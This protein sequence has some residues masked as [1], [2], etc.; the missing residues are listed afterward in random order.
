[1]AVPLTRID[2]TMMRMI[3]RAP[4]L[5]PL[6][7]LPACKAEVLMPTGDIAAQQRD[8]L[9]W[10]TLIM[11]I[12]IVPVLVLVGL[13]AWRYRARNRAA[14]YA[15]DWSHSTKLELVIW[16]IPA[17]III[18]L[19]AITWV[20]THHLDPYRPIQRISADRPLEDQTPLVVET[21][22]L[23]WK[24][25]FIYPEQGVATVNELVV[26]VDRPIEFRL[27]SSSVMN[28]FYIPSMAGMIYSMP[29]M[30]TTLHGI[31]NAEGSFQGMSSHYSGAGFSGMRFKAHAVTDE[32]FEDWAARTRE[33]EGN[34]DREEYLA[35]AQPSENVPPMQYGSV[36]PRLFSR[37]VNMCVE[38]GKMCMAEMMAIDAQGGIGL[39]GTANMQ[40]RAGQ[41]DIRR[42]DRAPTLGWQP[43]YVT[44]LCTPAE[45]ELMLTLR[46]DLPPPP[47]LNHAPM[48]GHSL[49]Q[50]GTGLAEIL[51][52]PSP[53]LTAMP[54]TADEL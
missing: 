40:A 20:G 5:I 54:Q 51:R 44:G 26:P 53:V 25:L 1:M 12:I 7:M 29:G 34:L 28:A 37:V 14:T 31:F 18:A 30:E 35:L 6:M 8:L 50:P 10:A 17:L 19:G 47:P 45:E 22:S 41:G 16:A 46:A 32:A 13:F 39:A 48:R 2:K 49:P 42:G 33:A 21:V 4:W 36:D 38:E 24:W 11:L 27:T 43:F 3:K 15:P 9:V 23:D 52:R